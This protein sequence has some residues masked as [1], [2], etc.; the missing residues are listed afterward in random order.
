M[1]SRTQAKFHPAKVRHKLH[2]LGAD[3]K[4]AAH[5]GDVLHYGRLRRLPMPKPMSADDWFAVWILGP[6]LLGF[7]YTCLLKLIAMAL[8]SVL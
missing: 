2:A 5:S 4:N 7:L 6:I 8:W 3:H 1:I